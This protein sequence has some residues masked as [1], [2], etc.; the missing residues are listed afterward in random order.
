MDFF[1][2]LSLSVIQGLLYLLDF[3]TAHVSVFLQYSEHAC[4]IPFF[5]R[6]VIFKVVLDKRSH[7]DLELRGTFISPE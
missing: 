2:F 4:I 1:L 7:L 3:L 6:D 5:Q